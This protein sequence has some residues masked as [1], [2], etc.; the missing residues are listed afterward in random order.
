MSDKKRFDY[1]FCD[2]DGTLLEDKQRHYECYKAIVNKYGGNCI[3]PDEYWNDKRDKVKRT[4]L[5]EKSGFQGTYDDYLSEWLALI[6]TPEFLKYET[7]KPDTLSFLEWLGDNSEHIVL[8][9]QRRNRENLL[10]QLEKLGI[11]GYFE[12]VAS[13]DNKPDILD[14]KYNKDSLVIGDTEAD[15]ETAERLGCTFIAVTSG[16]RNEKYLAADRKITALKELYESG[17]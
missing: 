7:L 9:T 14:G 1:V 15:E 16:L 6:E 11:S 4:V 8:T 17:N 2:L 3:P 10:S 5:L 13:G 12:E